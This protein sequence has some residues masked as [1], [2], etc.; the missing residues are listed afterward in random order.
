VGAETNLV[1]MWMSPGATVRGR[2]AFAGDRTALRD[3]FVDL[4]GWSSKLGAIERDL[5]FEAKG[6]QPGLYRVD[7]RARRG[8]GDAG[9]TDGSDPFYV[10]TVLTGQSDVTESGIPA[11][12]RQGPLNVEVVLG[13]DGGT[14]KGELRDEAGQPLAESFVVLAPADLRY[15]SSARHF[16][17]VATDDKGR[18]TV[19]G[20]IPGTYLLF[21][22]PYGSVHNLLRPE[23]FLRLQPFAAKVAVEKESEVTQDME[24]TKEFR[25]MV[26]VWIP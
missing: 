15:R 19:R 21:P 4:V 10:A 18:F 6:V 26:D 23:L 16:K 13:G 25:A 7:I 12:E 3:R 24:V 5:T 2:I 22:W 11:A 17:S 14:V 8:V 20:I 9:L 1:T